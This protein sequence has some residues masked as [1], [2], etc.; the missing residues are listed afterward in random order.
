MPIRR[1]LPKKRVSPASHPL[2]A[3]DRKTMKKFEIEYL[4]TN[5]LALAKNDGFVYNTF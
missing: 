3:K 4:Y 2:L 5:T 1:F